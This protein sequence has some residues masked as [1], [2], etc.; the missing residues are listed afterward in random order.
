MFSIEAVAIK[1]IGA[2]FDNG[3]KRLAVHLIGDG[4]PCHFQNGWRDIFQAS[5]GVRSD[6]LLLHVAGSNQQR[7]V[8]GTFVGEDL[9]EEMVITEQLAVVGGEDD[10]GGLISTGHAVIK[11]PTEH[12]RD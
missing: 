11:D 6:R 9:A 2:S 4:D 8:S 7:H 5:D 10:P 12:E 1:R 3:E